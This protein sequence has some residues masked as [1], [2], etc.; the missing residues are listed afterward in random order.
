MPATVRVGI[1][2][3][4]VP[5]AYR[6]ADPVGSHLQQY[7]AYFNCVEINSSF[8]K[9]HR[10]TT[11]ARWAD[12]VPPDFRFSAK[13]PKLITHEHRLVACEEAVTQFCAAV[14]GLRDKL[15]VVLVQLPPSLEFDARP[16]E[17]VFRLLRAASSATIVC[18]ARHLSWFQPQVDRVFSALGVMRVLADPAIDPALQIDA[19]LPSVTAT[20]QFSY[21]RLHGRPRVY[22][23]SYSPQ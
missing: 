12:S 11:F 7:A 9:P 8:Y 20:G 14:A 2:G 21:L 4:S 23:S 3:W 19:A 16:V 13:L 5:A 1:A 18:E 15:A 10:L 6:A 17:V 22:Y